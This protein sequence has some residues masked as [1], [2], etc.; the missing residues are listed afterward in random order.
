MSDEA[1]DHVV[2]L[3][4]R[5]LANLVAK[6]VS[7]E[8]L[9]SRAVKHLFGHLWKLGNKEQNGNG[10]TSASNCEVNELNID[11]V[12]SILAREEEL[13]GDQ[14]ADERSNTVPR[15]AELKTS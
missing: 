14:G 2:L 12:I 4:E 6:L 11:Q 3:V 8:V 15:L 9:D 1:E 13:G 5:T 7:C 10:N